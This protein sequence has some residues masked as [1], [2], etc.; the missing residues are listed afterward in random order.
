MDYNKDGSCGQYYSVGLLT[1]CQLILQKDLYIKF[2]TV[3]IYVYDCHINHI[4]I[5][6]YIYQ[7]MNNSVTRY[8]STLLHVYLHVL[9]NVTTVGSSCLSLPSYSVGVDVRQPHGKSKLHIQVFGILG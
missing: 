7:L 5:Y 8:F 2:S 1:A 9:L 4:Y 3:N 6:I